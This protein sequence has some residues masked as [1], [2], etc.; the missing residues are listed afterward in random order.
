MGS[1]ETGAY[2]APSK[3]CPR[4]R[5][6]HRPAGQAIYRT[7]RCI[8][9][10]QA[11]GSFCVGPAAL[12][13]RHSTNA[14]RSDATKG[15]S[16][17]VEAAVRPNGHRENRY[18]ELPGLCNRPKS[19]GESQPVEHAVVAG[20]TVRSASTIAAKAQRWSAGGEMARTEQRHIKKKW[21]VP[22]LR[23]PMDLAR[24]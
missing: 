8:R 16:P 7:E 24:Q 20:A 22:H 18:P 5:Q 2:L 3:Q 14:P 4:H 15:N 1:T 10:H 23:M 21:G 12:R 6:G 9:R 11:T 17:P 13:W 19:R